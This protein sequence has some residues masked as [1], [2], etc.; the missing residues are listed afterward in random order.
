MFRLQ[1]RHKVFTTLS[2]LKDV[3]YALAENYPTNVA[4]TLLPSEVR[5]QSVLFREV[6]LP[7]LFWRVTERNLDNCLS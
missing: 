4:E 7:S 1:D 2:V 5:F 3:I 6:L